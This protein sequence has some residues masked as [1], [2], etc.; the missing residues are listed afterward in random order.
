MANDPVAAAAK[1]DT[2]ATQPVASAEAPA[3]A[4]PVT[5]VAAPS[6]APL[7]GAD[8]AKREGAPEAKPDAK[9]D[10]K[11]NG[12]DTGAEAA[13]PDAAAKPD[14]GTESAAKAPPADGGEAKPP[15]P[16]PDAPKPDVQA[17]PE[18]EAKPPEPADNKDATAETPQAPPVYDALKVPETV[19]LDNERVKKFDE[20]IGKTEV[21]TKAD[22]A[23]MSALRQELASLYVEEAT[24]ITQE[25]TRKQVDVWNRLTEQR[26]NDLKNDP[27]YG[28]NRLE[29]SL[30][31]A[32]YT[33]EAL[34]PGFTKQDAADWIA[35]ADAGGVSH[36][37]LTVK[38]L[39]GLYELLREPDAISPAPPG[40]GS[41]FKQP[42]ARGW[43][44][45]VDGAKG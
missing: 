45:T 28:G 10:A 11:P 13:K 40:M 18:G 33:L 21:A 24:R 42:G 17:K 23:A 39:N 26:F 14:S 9:T 2:T 4:A 35:I 30:G 19:K 12:H 34:V 25:M 6:I 43:Y 41:Q 15:E 20:L 22:H 36:H 7:A 16:K 44:D 29:T 38:L 5:E 1:P 37:K 3:A 32:K 31:N 8:A 27:Q